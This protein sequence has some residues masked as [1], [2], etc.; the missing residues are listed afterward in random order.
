MFGA[1]V[2]LIGDEVA[3]MEVECAC[4]HEFAVRVSRNTAAQS[5]TRCPKCGRTGNVDAGGR[6]VNSADDRPVLHAM[7]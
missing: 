1:C 7:E 3:V 5:V 2:Q 4:G 6:V